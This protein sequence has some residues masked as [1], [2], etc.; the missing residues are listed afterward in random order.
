MFHWSMMW[1]GINDCLLFSFLFDTIYFSKTVFNFWKIFSSNLFYMI[2]LFKTELGSMYSSLS[3]IA[4]IWSIYMAFSLI[5][6]SFN[7]YFYY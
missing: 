4:L 3:I 5:I 6:S 7:S 1:C 2:Y